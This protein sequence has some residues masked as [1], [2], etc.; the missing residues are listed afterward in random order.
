MASSQYNNYIVAPNPAAVLNYPSGC[1]IVGYSTAAWD[2]TLPA[3]AAGAIGSVV[4]IASSN[5]SN[6]NYTYRLTA[7]W[8]VPAATFAGTPTGN[9]TLFANIGARNIAASSA[10]ARA[11]TITGA[12]PA[13]AGSMSAVFAGGSNIT[14]ALANDTGQNL[15]SGATLS[16]YSFSLE[17]IST[18]NFVKNTWN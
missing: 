9:L 12:V 15:N 17:T 13:V 6:S 5:T 3:I 14:F 16:F 4:S 11:T 8:I 18:S 10:Y 7:D 1:N 2:I